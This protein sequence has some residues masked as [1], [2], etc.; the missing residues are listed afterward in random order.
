MIDRAQAEALLDAAREVRRRSYSPYSG[1]AVGAA[2][3]DRQGLVHVGTNIENASYG[4]T[5]CAER[6]ALACAVSRGARDFRAIAIVGP[7]SEPCFPCGSCRQVLHEFAP[8]LT[9]VLEGSG[10]EPK[11]MALTALLPEPF[12]SAALRTKLEEG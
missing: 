4:L 2:L 12:P 1:F 5:M 10:G 7:G 6:N 8:D 3:L 11:M 9:I